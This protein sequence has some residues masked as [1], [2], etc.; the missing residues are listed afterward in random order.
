MYNED[1]KVFY[2]TASPICYMM[3]SLWCVLTAECCRSIYLQVDIEMSFVT[4]DGIKALI[5]D[6]LKYSWPVNLPALVTPF[7]RMRYVDAIQKY[8]SDKPDTRFDMLVSNV[9]ACTH[10]CILPMCTPCVWLLHLRSF[11]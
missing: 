10:A 11:N 7:S 1:I 8:G 5:E 2:N 6:L 4:Q 3:A 9:H